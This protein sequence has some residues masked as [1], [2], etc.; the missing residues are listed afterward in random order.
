MN[1]RSL[2]IGFSRRWIV[3]LSVFFMAV[4]F[5]DFASRVYV[6]RP[7]T[8]KRVAIPDV[9]V[10][11]DPFTAEGMRAKLL[12]WL[13]P[14]TAAAEAAKL[15]TEPSLKAIFKSGAATY[16]VFF[17]VRDDGVVVDRVKAKV[18]EPVDDWIVQSVAR[19][20][21]VLTR[22]GESRTLTLF[23]SVR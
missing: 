19:P 11:P 14:E 15:K 6:P 16:A 3:G 18:G 12:R 7:D 21:V 23:K 8:N 2:L 22:D 20:N 1:W 4:F 9:S 5:L 13:P 10:P 17:L